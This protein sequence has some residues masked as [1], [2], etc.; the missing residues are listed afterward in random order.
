MGWPPAE[1]PH[2]L[3]LVFWVA[4]FGIPVTLESL[5][6]IYVSSPVCVHTSSLNSRCFC[7]WIYKS[8]EI[9]PKGL[10]TACSTVLNNMDFVKQAGGRCVGT[11]RKNKI[12][13][14][15]VL[16]SLYSE[17]DTSTRGWSPV[18]CTEFLKMWTG[19]PLRLLQPSTSNSIL[20][21]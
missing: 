12:K 11:I 20:L 19:W 6:E 14:I 8:E 5:K 3:R 15:A 21:C 4:K 10:T 17:D 2:Y 9:T 18:L 1:P 16:D 13:T 7:L